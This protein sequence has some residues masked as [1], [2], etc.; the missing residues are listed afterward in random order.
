MAASKPRSHVASTAP[1]LRSHAAMANTRKR[2][3]C[4]TAAGTLAG[5]VDASA[6]AASKKQFETSIALSKEKVRRELMA[7]LLGG[8]NVS[9]DKALRISKGAAFKD[10][11]EE[12]APHII[13]KKNHTGNLTTTS[14]KVIAAKTKRNAGAQFKDPYKHGIH[15]VMG[16]LHK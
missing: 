2:T 7:M 5:D 9:P 12:A 16:A 1:K 6:G 4:T 13:S 11:V 14:G 8:C 3:H 10:L 15:R